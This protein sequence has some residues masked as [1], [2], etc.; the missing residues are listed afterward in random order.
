M[1]LLENME[2]IYSFRER[3]RE[4]SAE[5]KIENETDLTIGREYSETV[6][7]KRE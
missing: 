5:R 2:F 6:R 7:K 1:N 3:D 4:K